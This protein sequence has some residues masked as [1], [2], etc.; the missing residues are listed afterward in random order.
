MTDIIFPFLRV[1]GPLKQRV[2]RINWDN[3]KQVKSVTCPTFFISGEKDKLVPQEMTRKLFMASAS[4]KKDIWIVEGG[5][6]NDIIN[7]AGSIYV[8]KLQNFFW[9]CRSLKTTKPLE[10]ETELKKER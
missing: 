1:I 8:T 3:L 9:K 2:L 6:H 4:S 10:L 5:A 7:L